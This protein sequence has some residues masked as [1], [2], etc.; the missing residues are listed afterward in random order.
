MTANPRKGRQ[1]RHTGRL[2]VRGVPVRVPRTWLSI[3]AVLAGI[4][5]NLTTPDGTRSELIGWYSAAALVVIGSIAS[6]LGH[7]IAHDIV[8]RRRGTR[9]HRFEMSAMGALTDEAFPP[10]NPADDAIVA[11]IGPTVSLGIGALL[12]FGW[13]LLLGD[14][15]VATALGA[16]SV[17]N[18]ALGII[19]ILPGYPTDGGRILRAFL[20]YLSDD[21]I[22]ATQIVSIY[23]QIIGF[24]IVLSGLLLL[25]LGDTWSVA[26]AWLLF[27]YWSI[28]Q[29]AR[30]SLALTLL[31]EGGRRVTVD[32]AGLGFSRRIA[33]ERTIDAALDEILQSVE[34]GPL[35][36]QQDGAIVGLVSLENIRRVPRISW[37]TVTVGQI[38]SPLDDI[39]R[40]GGEWTLIDILDLVDDSA[41]NVA[42]IVAGEHIVGAVDRNLIHARIRA[43]L[44]RPRMELPRRGAR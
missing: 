11:A 37:D 33:G 26:A 24:G 17:V 8:A 13:W 28:S 10:E 23:G 39:P 12:G 19:T 3:A 40:A 43:Q 36:V 18:L 5:I 27:A 32:E 22:S 42:L 16:L 9:L 4:S 20:W 7:E 14:S 1:T 35:L 44:R 31:R 2:T 15:L 34:S 25:A 29:S 6:L 30:Q 21:L 41:T 38:A